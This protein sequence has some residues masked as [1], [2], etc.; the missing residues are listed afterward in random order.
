MIYIRIGRAF[1]FAYNGEVR[2][3]SGNDLGCDPHPILAQVSDFTLFALDGKMGREAAPLLES[4][5]RSLRVRLA[6]RF[7]NIADRMADVLDWA[8]H[9]PDE[10][11][12]VWDPNDKTPNAEP[13]PTEPKPTAAVQPPATAER[14]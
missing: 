13:P 4:A 10:R 7:W 9:Y 12:K 3:G 8:E 6:G 14:K 11:F 5:I 2:Q 1:G